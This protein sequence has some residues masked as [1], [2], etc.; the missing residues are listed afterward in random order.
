M[1]SGGQRAGEYTHRP[2]DKAAFM[3]PYINVEDLVVGKTLLLFLNAR[4]RNQPYLFAHADFEAV[5]FG[6]VSH[7]IG[8]AFLNEYTMYLDGKTPEK[9]GRLV[10]WGD[11]DNA[12]DDM[13]SGRARNP[14]EGLVV[15]EI[16]KGIMDF[17]L[18]CVYSIFHDTDPD[19]LTSPKV[20]VQP[21]PPAITAEATEWPTLA[22]W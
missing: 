20:E 13:H 8:I 11:D 16:Q 9:Y 15:L 18:E 14:G 1:H 2:E 12:Y 7:A 22:A 3:W 19:L 6:Q 5:R 17:L 4:G 21:E 10:S